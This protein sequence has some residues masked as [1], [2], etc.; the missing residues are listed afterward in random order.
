MYAVSVKFNDKK[1]DFLQSAYL[2]SLEI[3]Q[4]LGSTSCESIS[5]SLSSHTSNIRRH[6]SLSQPKSQLIHSYMG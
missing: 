4:G 2:H 6:I 1:G 5:A 3:P